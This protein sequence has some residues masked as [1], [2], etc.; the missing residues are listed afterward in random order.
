MRVS[1]VMLLVVTG[2]PTMIPV[3]LMTISPLG[4]IHCTTGRTLTSTMQ[5][6]LNLSPAIPVPDSE[7]VISCRR[8]GEE[9]GNKTFI[10]EWQ[11]CLIQVK[12]VCHLPSQLESYPTTMIFTIR[13]ALVLATMNAS[14]ALGL[15]IVLQV[16]VPV[17]FVCS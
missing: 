8:S 1:F 7:M 10:K 14:D 9:S 16:Q 6:T 17:S 5:V 12:I 13:V 11:G 3:L 4:Y 15:E 2:G